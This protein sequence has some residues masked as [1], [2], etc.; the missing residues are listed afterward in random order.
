MKMRKVLFF[1][2]LL[3]AFGFAGL[4]GGQVFAQDA[5]ATPEAAATVV[6]PTSA[7]VTETAAAI[8]TAAPTETAAASATVKPTEASTVAT[9]VASTTAPT[10]AATV[11]AT[12]AVSVETI[13]NDRSNWIWVLGIALLAL[14]FYGYFKRLSKRPRP[15][16]ERCARCG[17]DMTGKTGPCP[18]CGSTRKLPK[19]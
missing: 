9:T 10:A 12:K 8:A 17:F 4:I 18:Q 7:P 6:P 2:S 5:T 16:A 15:S 13:L 19:L 14:Y 1:V 11:T 3:L